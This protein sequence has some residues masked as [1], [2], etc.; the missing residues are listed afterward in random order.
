MVPVA[1]VLLAAL[2]V[3][4]A[5]A[6][7]IPECGVGLVNERAMATLRATRAAAVPESR[8]A[9]NA[10]TSTPSFENGIVVLPASDRIIPFHRPFNLSERSVR[11][12]R[13][14]ATESRVEAIPFAWNNDLGALKPINGVNRSTLVTLPFDFPF[15]ERVVR[16]IAIGRDNAIWLD[17]SAPS[18]ELAQWGPLEIL[19]LREPVIS[20]LLL[21]TKRLGFNEPT[22]H[23]RDS[24]SSVQYTWIGT[25]IRGYQTQV[26]LEASGDVVMSWKDVTL[27][28]GSPV[29]SDGAADQFRSARRLL[30]ESTLASGDS[31][32]GTGAL[33]AALDMTG[34]RIE[35]LGDSPLL[36][37]RIELSGTPAGIA[38]TDQALQYI[39]A[40][41][42]P[43]TPPGSEPYFIAS[44]A[45]DG[46]VTYFSSPWAQTT[47]LPSARIDG[48][49]VV[50]SVIDSHLPVGSEMEVLIGTSMTGE[51]N[52]G[53]FA[54]L[55][56]D[57]EPGSSTELPFSSASGSWSD[58]PLY[59]AFTLGVLDPFAVAE[60]LRAVAGDSIDHLDGVAIY[61]TFLTDIIFFAGAYAYSGNAVANGI[62]RGQ[63]L[64]QPFTPALMHMNALG[65]GHNA[66]PDGAM[67][68][69]LHEFGHRWLYSPSV[70]VDGKASRILNPISAHPAQYVHT[71][72]AFPVITDKDT[73]VMG[74]GWFEQEGAGW[75]TPSHLTYYGYSWLDLYLMGMADPNE[76]P[77]FFYLDGTELG[78]A[79]Y[80]PQGAFVSGTK[81]DVHVDSVIAATGIRTPSAATSKRRFRAAVVV[82]ESESE[83]FTEATRVEFDQHRRYVEASFSKATGNRGE[84]TLDYFFPTSE[85]RRRG[86][87]R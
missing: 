59:E 2:A 19:S 78:G 49:D 31:S 61:Q 45:K 36:E 71:S 86:A 3:S 76:V 46:K 13:V 12:R 37:V 75:R 79:Y 65:Y 39:L 20:P 52:Y 72:A 30:A 44:V 22:L 1:V 55:E 83:P 9:P 14:G 63:L 32:I 56:I 84:L 26:T 5:A 24:G 38:P 25:G 66:T 6:S 85:P 17:G 70:M 51:N 77:P 23:A 33:A 54:V 15:R 40:F 4:P 34:V 42:T 47:G 35:R 28:W 57:F 80:P 27:P 10:E 43:Q 73:S 7:E 8:F 74:G 68:V 81:R 69:L 48:D 29:I 41:A 53:D 11:V 67:R 62:G 16:N 18:H 64:D 58:E 50:L 82:I 60:Q 87:R 21:G